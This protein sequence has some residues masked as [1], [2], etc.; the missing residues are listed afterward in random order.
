MLLFKSKSDGRGHTGFY[1]SHV[2]MR[3]YS[4]M[5]DGKNFF[6]QPVGNNIRT[7]N[8]FHK[9]LLYPMEMII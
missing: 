9:K 6:N 1:L 7:C 8:N 4:V 2:E 5:I 3:D